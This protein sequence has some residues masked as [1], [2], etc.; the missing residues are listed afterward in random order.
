[1]H[2]AYHLATRSEERRVLAS[3]TLIEM[4]EDGHDIIWN[5][6]PVVKDL[7]GGVQH[8]YWLNQ[9]PDKTESLIK[10]QI[11]HITSMTENA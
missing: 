1:V 8:T 10:R 3:Q 9:L 7:H 5:E 2:W 6:G 4:L 11:K